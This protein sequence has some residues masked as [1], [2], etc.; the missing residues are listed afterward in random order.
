MNWKA[1]ILVLILILLRVTAVSAQCNSTQ[2]DINSANATLLDEI[3]GVGQAKAHSIIDY[4]A[5]FNFNSVDD[6]IN[7]SGIGN[8]TLE[9]I[10]RQGLACVEAENQTQS[11]VSDNN[12]SNN[13]G[14]SNSE[15]ISGNNSEPAAIS[16]IR[17][18]VTHSSNPSRL[19]PTT[20][21]TISLNSPSKKQSK[22]SLS[23]GNNLSVYGLILF[24]VVLGLL[25]A[26]RKF[27]TK[28]YKS[29]FD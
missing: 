24:S 7:V 12:V 4:R 20:H 25:F 6:L 21:A 22:T 17:A 9:E 3:Y 14:L 19:I 16:K 11:P 27:R 28:R 15:N 13:S 18:T 8:V 26:A 10:K 5:I 29:E 23:G 2:I 1:T